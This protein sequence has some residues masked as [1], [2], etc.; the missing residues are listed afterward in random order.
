[1][2][3]GISLGCHFPSELFLGEGYNRL[4]ISPLI[5]PSAIFVSLFSPPLHLPRLSAPP[6][7]PHAPGF[8][9]V[10]DGGVHL[11]LL[12]Q[13][14]SPGLLQFHHLAGEGQAGQF[15]RYRGVRR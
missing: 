4:K 11:F 9:E 2:R 15:H 8:N 1:M 13:V 3:I 14:V 10:V 12:D 5:A 7:P 6:P